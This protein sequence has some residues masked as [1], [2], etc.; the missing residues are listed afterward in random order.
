MLGGIRVAR[1]RNIKPSIMANEEL[2]ELEPLSRLLFI[3]LWMLADREGRLEDRPKR[4][5]AQALAYDRSADVDEMLGSLE[6]SGFISRYVANGLACIQILA[7]VKHQTPHGTEKDSVLPDPSGAFT[8]HK[9]GNNGYSTGES[10]LVNGG[11]TVKQQ[12]QNTLNPDSGFLNPDSLNP[13]CGATAP[14]HTLPEKFLEV[15]KSKRPELDP[16]TVYRKFCGHKPEKQQTLTTWTAW[17]Q[18]EQAGSPPPSTADPDSRASIEALGMAQ[19]IGKW[20][21]LKEPWAKYKNRVKGQP[22]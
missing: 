14:T 11:L 2:A 18:N 5:A 12:S 17:V 6:K 1:S 9:R 20:N 19:G 10:E 21:E 7:F 15:I 13:E 4:I 16:A 3:Y 8:V 22:A